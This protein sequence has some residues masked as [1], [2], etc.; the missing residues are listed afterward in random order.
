M[1]VFFPELPLAVEAV[2]SCLVGVDTVGVPTSVYA[3]FRTAWIC[4]WFGDAVP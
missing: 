2:F 1:P 4:S 3:F